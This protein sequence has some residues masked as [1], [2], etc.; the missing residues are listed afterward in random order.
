VTSTP[1]RRARRARRRFN[2]FAVLCLIAALALTVL[3]VTRLGGADADAEAYADQVLC[4]QGH[5]AYCS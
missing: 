2:V 4:E 1:P 5:D 3:L